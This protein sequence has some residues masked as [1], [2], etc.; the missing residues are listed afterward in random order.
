MDLSEFC[1][2]INKPRLV[3]NAITPNYLP[4]QLAIGIHM[5]AASRTVRVDKN[6]SLAPSIT[7]VI[8]AGCSQAK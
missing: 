2:S 6:Y 1:D 5:Y 8:V 7:T 4:A 3:D